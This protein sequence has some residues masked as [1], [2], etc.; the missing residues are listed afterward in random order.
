MWFLSES[1]K[2][3]KAIINFA[4][5]GA[6][7]RARCL[8][9]ILFLALG[10]FL[11]PRSGWGA[12]TLEVRRVG[13]SRVGENTLLT[14]MV[15]R[16]ANPLL[17]QRTEA[18][19]PQIILDFAQAQHGQLPSRL[20]GD[21]LLVEQVRTESLPSRTG[22][23]IILDLF[24]DRPYTF[25]RLSKPMGQD[26]AVFIIGL[27][28]EGDVP[29]TAG[30]LPSQPREPYQPLPET[31]RD[32]QL[33]PVPEPP[34]GPASP[35]P[36]DYRQEGRAPVSGNF[37]DLK[38]LIP[39]AAPLL[40]GLEAD[41]WVVADSH[42]YDR[43]GQ[44]FSRDFILTNG[45]YPDLVV[46]IANLPA[47]VPGEPSINFI[48]LGVDHLSGADAEKYQKLRQW[49]FSR[50]RQDYEDIGDFFDDALKPLRVK[51]R[52]ESQ[53]LVTRQASVWQGFLQRA[54]PGN[55]RVTDQALAHLQE[56]VN[57][58]F[59]G[60]QYT[61]SENPLVILNLVDYPYVRV[62]FLEGSG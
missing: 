26:Q 40:Q 23:R 32:S 61:L 25:W 15:N 37:A 47:N 2:E 42:T 6:K 5:P 55:S 29:R 8:L 58:R 31:E 36:D 12:A 33:Q 41:G 53:R 9:G 4:V 38:R 50:I 34:P 60:V 3:D 13:L 28:T 24:P 49:N 57:Q 54:C 14:V 1:Q 44:R 11:W 48:S 35:G 17:I 7:I 46:K 27:K 21:D 45:R 30:I 16:P 56:K 39:K 19:K 52:A 10:G 51:L 43:P 22:V 20:A 18:G 62:Y 59:E